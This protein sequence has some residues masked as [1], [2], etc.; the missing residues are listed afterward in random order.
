M[1]KK[2]SMIAAAGAFLMI[3]SS[4]QAFTPAPLN[5]P[6]AQMSDVEHVAQ[7]CGQGWAR[8]GY[9]RCV[10]MRAYRPAVV[11]RQVMTPYGWRRVC[12]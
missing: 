7:G 4:A 11:C 2:I 1:L 8:N 12:R 6:A 9:G 5:S 10:P 3:A